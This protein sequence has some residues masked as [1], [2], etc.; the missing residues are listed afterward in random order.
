MPDEMRELPS[1]TNPNIE[2]ILALKPDAVFVHSGGIIESGRD[3][4]RVLKSTPYGSKDHIGLF[5][6]G[7]ARVIAAA[8]LAEYFPEAKIVTNSTVTN[9][10]G[11]VEPHALVYAAELRDKHEVPDSQIIVQEDSIDTATELIELM[12]MTENMGWKRVVMITNDYHLPRAKAIFENLE[13]LAAKNYEEEDSKEV[14][15]LLKRTK[16]AGTELIFQGAE[17]ILE[18]RSPHYKNL[19]AAAQDTQAFKD[20]VAAE[21]NGVK[22]ILDGT[23][24][25]R[26]PKT[27]ASS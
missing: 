13:A 23:Y 12:R 24:K 1:E 4:K 5:G 15:K 6:G 19:I 2:R 11:Q 22:Q 27:R 14:A 9:N 20:R 7:K 21:A 26:K 17:E 25:L 18:L 3:D 8:Q 16:E 10:L